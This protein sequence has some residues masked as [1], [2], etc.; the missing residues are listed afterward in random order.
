MSQ[1]DTFD[2]RMDARVDPQGMRRLYEVAGWWDDDD[3]RRPDLEWLRNMVAGSFCFAAAYDDQG[4]MIGMGRAISDGVSDA[5]IQD[6]VV[7]PGWRRQGVGAAIM[8][9]LM[10]R[11]REQHINWIGLIA[12]PGSES[13][14]SALGFK[15]M[16]GHTP[17]R[18]LG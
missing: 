4:R 7:D 8:A 2:I 6:V 10:K 18:L 15:P 16:D 5:Y 1:H 3:D 9:A 17:M 14:Y 12:E 11:L 13:F